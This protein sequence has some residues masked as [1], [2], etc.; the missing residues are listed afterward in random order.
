MARLRKRSD[1]NSRAKRGTYITPRA[2]GYARTIQ[3][4]Y[5][6][7]LRLSPLPRRKPLPLSTPALRARL[8]SDSRRLRREIS[9]YWQ[10][11]PQRSGMHDTPFKRPRI[12]PYGVWSKG[13][14]YLH[15]PSVKVCVQRKQRREALFATTG[16]GAIRRKPTNR[17]DSRSELRCK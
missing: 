4:D 6:P 11:T 9:A 15:P 1:R 8:E 2:S 17:R 16:G 12:Q 14:G 10:T 7:S 5:W 13:L 3:S